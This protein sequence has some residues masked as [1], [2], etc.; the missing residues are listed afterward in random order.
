VRLEVALGRLER[1]IDLSL[2]VGPCRGEHLEQRARPGRLARLQRRRVPAPT[3]FPA[4]ERHQ[5]PGQKLVSTVLGRSVR[6]AGARTLDGAPELL[7][8]SERLLHVRPR[9]GQEPGRH[10]RLREVSQAARLVASIADGVQLGPH[11]AE[12]RQ[13]IPRVTTLRPGPRQVHPHH[14]G[15]AAVATGLERGQGLLEERRA[16]G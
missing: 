13:S 14:Q 11:G 8:E 6:R 3:R 1:R 4:L 7:G 10:L 2:H 12:R 15:R 16:S 5:H 9:L